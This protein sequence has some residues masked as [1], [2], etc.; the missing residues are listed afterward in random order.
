MVSINLSPNTTGQAAMSIMMNPPQPGD[1][2]YELYE[3]V[4]RACSV[5]CRASVLAVL[6][7]VWHVPPGNGRGVAGSK[8]ST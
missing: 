5:Y 7:G 8:N 3:Q 2:S 1:E 6:V 4:L